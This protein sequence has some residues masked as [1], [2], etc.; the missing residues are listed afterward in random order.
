MEQKRVLE[1]PVTGYNRGGLL[2]E[3]NHLQ[4][5]VPVS[6]LVDFPPYADENERQQALENCKDSILRLRI[7][8]VDVRRKRLVLSERA[9][10]SEEAERRDLLQNLQPGDHC[11]GRVTSLC[12]FGAFVDLGGLEGLIH[13]SQL[14]WGR[15]DHPAEVLSPGQDVEVVVLNVDP[16]RGRIGLSICK[17]QPDPWASVQDRYFVG[18]I[19]EGKITSVV[20]F[21]AFAQVEEGIEGLI[22]VSELAEGNFLHPR[23]IVQEEQVLAL[24]VINVDSQRRRLGLS[25]R[26]VAGFEGGSSQEV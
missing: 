11:R 9:T 23:N 17:A 4:G 26:Q 22:H 5:F 20:D 3:W 10:C 16:E 15:V 24:R 14:S 12:S 7:I 2:V 8:E 21:G 6:H 19:V 25:L 18:Q 1:L 13:I